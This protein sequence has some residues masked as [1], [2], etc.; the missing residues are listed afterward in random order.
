MFSFYAIKSI[1]TP[2][3]AI[4]RVQVQIRFKELAETPEG[5]KGEI[6]FKP[7][8]VYCLRLRNVVVIFTNDMIGGCCHQGKGHRFESLREDAGA[9]KFVR[10]NIFKNLY[11]E[12]RI[13]LPLINQGN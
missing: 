1:N 3:R 13:H 4:L 8:T 10:V 11:F 6:A 2:N 5:C 12:F 9:K 7:L